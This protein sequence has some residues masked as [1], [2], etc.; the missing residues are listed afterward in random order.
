[1]KFRSPLGT[2]HSHDDIDYFGAQDTLF[3]C[4][5]FT[6]LNAWKHIADNTDFHQYL[7]HGKPPSY[8]IYD[9]GQSI[10]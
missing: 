8:I 4:L 6:E 5:T 10:G 2:N 3:P 1:M 9:V 7:T